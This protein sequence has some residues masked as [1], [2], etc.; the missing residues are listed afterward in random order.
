[1]IYF[2]Y[3]DNQYQIRARFNELK[4]NFIKKH[5]AE[6]VVKLDIGE[7]GWDAV[8]NYLV[9]VSLFA[10]DEFLYL[11]EA[12]ADAE[13]WRDLEEIISRVS[14]EKTVVLIDDISTR[15]VKNLAQTRTF[16]ALKASGKVE[17]Y[18][19]LKPYEI[20]RWLNEATRRTG[21]KLDAAASRRLLE[22]TAG[23]NDQQ[24][25][26][27]LAL[28]LLKV[29]P[30]PLTAAQIDEYIEPDVETATF[31]IFRQMVVHNQTKV[32]E[33]LKRQV[34]QGVDP[35]QLVGVLAS[36]LNN[37]VAV[38]SGANVKMHPFQ[39]EQMQSMVSMMGGQRTSLDWAQKTAKKL[40]TADAKIK[41]SSGEAASQY[42]ADAILSLT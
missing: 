20:K 16:K 25:R 22:L 32:D 36:Q 40:A 18:E 4:D 10:R 30:Q 13:V 37:F 38:A 9:G 6:N 28:S 15:A 34:A 26:L 27:A 31:D 19:Q 5:N 17:K 12:T 1:M 23:S 3:G 39:K 42:L 24:N 41:R 14:P 33:L 21:V 11:E 7:M 8:M 35:N 29:L 2:L